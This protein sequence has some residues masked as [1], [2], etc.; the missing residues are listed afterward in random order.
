MHFLAFNSSTFSL[1]FSSN[2]VMRRN[3]YYFPVSLNMLIYNSLFCSLLNY[4]FL[5]WSTTTTVNISKVI[6]LQKKALRLA[7]KVP[8]RCHTAE[9]F[10]KYSIIQV[11]L[12]HDYKLSRPYKFGLLKDNGTIAIIARLEENFP[13]HN[14]CQPEVWYISKCRTN[15]GNQMLKFQL[16]TLLNRVTKKHNSDISST[17]PKQ[18]R[19]LFV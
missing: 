18:L 3:C 10:K 6:V 16:P 1:F 12:I 8:Y 13:A 19:L 5:L 9:L 7:C 15:Y 17:S 4:T 2:G 14:V 11:A